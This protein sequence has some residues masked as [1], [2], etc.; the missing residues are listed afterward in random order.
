LGKKQRKERKGKRRDIR[1]KEDLGK[2]YV[3]VM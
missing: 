2:I 3:H 1:G